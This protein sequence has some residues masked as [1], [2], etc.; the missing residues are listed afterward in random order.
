MSN[1][2]IDLYLKFESESEANL[3]LFKNQIINDSTIKIPEYSAIDI[4]GIIHKP[5]GNLIQSEEGMIPEI[6]PLEGW[7][8]NVRV[9][10]EEDIGKLEA[11]RIPE[12]KAPSRVWA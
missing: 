12:P 9:T 8:V 7:H 4:V 10:P 11:Y 1:E 2:Y 6:L 3:I 5:S